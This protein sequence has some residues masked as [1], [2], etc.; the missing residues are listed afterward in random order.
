MSPAAK[1]SAVVLM[2]EGSARGRVVGQ[3]RGDEVERPAGDEHAGRAASSASR[4][5]STS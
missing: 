4:H 5:D 3:N 2:D 1:S